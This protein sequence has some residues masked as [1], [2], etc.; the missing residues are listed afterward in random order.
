MHHHHYH[1]VEY[2]TV[3]G[4]QIPFLNGLSLQD[5]DHIEVLFPDG[6]AH[7]GHVLLDSSCCKEQVRPF[8]PVHFH[9]KKPWVFLIDMKAKRIC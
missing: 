5:K 2:K 7:K 3:D 4:V 9:G 8:L 6:T 1:T